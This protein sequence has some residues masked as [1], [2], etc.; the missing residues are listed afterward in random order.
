[1]KNRHALQP[2]EGSRRRPDKRLLDLVLTLMILPLAV[3]LFLLLML[4]VW[5]MLGSPI[6]FRQQ[7]PGLYGTP[8]TLLK[9]RTMTNACDE[10]GLLLLESHRLT[11]IGRFLRSTSLDELPELLN[12]LRGDMSLV[13]PRP[14]LM[15]YL[16]HYTPELQRRHHVL[17]GI[18]GWA[19]VNGRNTTT[20]ER[21]FALDLWYVDHQSLGLDLQILLL[22]VWKVLKKEGVVHPDDPL[23]GEPFKGLPSQHSEQESSRCSPPCRVIGIADR[24]PH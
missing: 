13:G 16:E 21:R 8:F 11:R 23:W 12:V 7:R 18:T 4:A 9:F 6:L 22:T 17:P 24:D 15:E 5:C 19:Q 1:M 2:S 20:W 10:A 14:L 3:P